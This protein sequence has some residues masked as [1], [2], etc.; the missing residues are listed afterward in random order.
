M[1]QLTCLFNVDHKHGEIIL[2][3]AFLFVVLDYLPTY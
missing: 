3:S 2:T 1:N